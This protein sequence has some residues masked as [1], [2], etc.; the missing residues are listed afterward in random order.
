MGGAGNKMGDATNGVFYGSSSDGGQT[1]A[2]PA[3]ISPENAPVPMYFSSPRVIVDVPRRLLYAVYTAGAAD[4]KWQ[5]MIATSKDAGVTWSNQTVNDDAACATHMMPAAQLD[6]ATGK[7]HV[8]WAENRSGVGAIAYAS[9]AAGGEKCGK[10]E[11]VSDTPFAAFG[12]ARSSARGLGD[13]LALVHDAK[14]KLLH[15][16]WTQ[17]VEE[18]G[19][20]QSRI[21]HAAAKLK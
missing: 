5:I 7:V 17:P 4:G 2:A 12:Y 20:V 15:A 10:N 13:Y 19:A 9:C 6:P 16:V 8:I 11:V 3:R 1:F 14:H 18:G 21:F